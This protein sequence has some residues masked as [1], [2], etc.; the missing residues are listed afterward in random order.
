MARDIILPQ[1]AMGMSEGTITEWLIE[2]GAEVA[3]EQPLVAIETEKVVTEIPAP[4]AG[5]VHIV[6]QSGQKLPVETI[7]A[8]ISSSLEEYKRLHSSGSIGGG[9]IAA[10]A[11]SAE[12]LAATASN[13]EM[14]ERQPVAR[15]RASGVAKALA[16]QR[17]IDL[18]SIVGT[19]PQGRIVKRDLEMV[20]TKTA[21]S[22]ALSKIS[23]LASPTLAVSPMRERA[24]IQV[25]GAR[26]IIAERMVKASTTAAQTFIFFEIDITRLIAAR[27]E[28][29]KKEKEIGARVSLLAFYARAVALAC[30]S[31]PIC[32]STMSGDEIV[33][34]DSVNVGIAVALPGAHEFGSNLVVPVVRDVDSKGVLEIHHEI[35]RQVARAR[36]GELISADMDGGTITISSTEGFLPGS[37]MVSTPLLNLPQVVNFQPGTPIE[38]P[39]VVDGQIS[40]RTVVPC[41]LAFDHRCMDGEPAGG[42]VRQLASL[43][44][45]PE[46]MLL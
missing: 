35:R 22:A 36:A 33:V 29:L 39:L 41:G 1:L 17:G 25:T 10:K 7:I 46:M 21:P 11:D 12:V 32:N 23:A 9:A 34:W 44:R 24:R 8:T 38:R 6:A 18:R 26:K 42:F 19:G 5:Y 37:W 31:V 15:L 14:L 20:S 4:T 27:N 30:K 3:R 40:I 28:L 13:S 2:E 45:D 16:K 43:L